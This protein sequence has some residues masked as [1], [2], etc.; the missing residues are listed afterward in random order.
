L[1]LGFPSYQPWGKRDYEISVETNSEVIIAYNVKSF[2]ILGA[3][4]REIIIYPPVESKFSIS[5]DEWNTMIQGNKH[6]HGNVS[7]FRSNPSPHKTSINEKRSIPIQDLLFENGKASFSL[8]LGPILATVDFEI[9]HSEIRKE[10]DAVKEY[11][12]KILG[13][14]NLEC[15]I[16]LDAVGKDIQSKSAHFCSGEIINGS[17]FEKV[18]DYVVSEA[19]L[20]SELDIAI[21]D[22]QLE[23]TA[24]LLSAKEPKDTNWLLDH[25]NKLKTSKHYH[26]L[27]YL[28]SRQEVAAFK[29]RIT[30]KPISFIFVIKENLQQFLVWETYET[31]EATYVWWLAAPD[32]NGQIKEVKDL[33]EKIKWLRASNKSQYIRLKLPNFKRIEH[34]YSGDDWGFEKWRAVLTSD[35]QLP[36][37][38][39]A[40]W[41][42]NDS[43]AF[44]YPQNQ[45]V[46][47]GFRYTKGD[48]FRENW[49]SSALFSLREPVLYGHYKKDGMYRF[50]WLR[51]FGPPVVFVLTR[52]GELLTLTTEC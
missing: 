3:P 16:K 26:H 13:T 51:A 50:L 36:L 31:E 6:I 35:I 42:P 32:R 2:D 48:T 40:A 18:E 47:L 12:E 22:D 34:D 4:P 33:L 27:R 7:D 10:F 21:V 44:Y 19:F 1:S 17:L 39:E 38:K 8:F 11:L 43:L 28:S 37:N 52:S 30:G 25:L 9:T 5:A 46:D 29:L 24:T 45:R 23:K 14:K 41:S 15:Q 49:Y 20:N